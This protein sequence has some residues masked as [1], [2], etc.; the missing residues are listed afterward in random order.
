MDC[1]GHTGGM[2][3]QGKGAVISASNT[4]KMKW[5]LWQRETSTI[6]FDG[7]MDSQYCYFSLIVVG[8]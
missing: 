6:V 4:R 1:R 7:V 3:S 5:R 2:M 8:A